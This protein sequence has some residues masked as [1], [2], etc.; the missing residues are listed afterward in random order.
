MMEAMPDNEEREYMRR[1]RQ[2]KKEMKDPYLH[3]EDDTN[4]E[5]MFEDLGVSEKEEVPE[6]DYFEKKE[7]PVR[8]GPT[9]RSHHEPES[10]SSYY[11][12]PSSDEESNPVDLAFSDDDGYVIP[13]NLASGSKRRL[14]KIRERVWYDETRENPHE[15]MGLRLCFI[16]VVQFRTSLRTFH[17]TQVRNFHYH[18]NN[19]KRIIV[20]CS[21]EGCPFYTKASM[22]AKEKTF[23]IRAHLH[24]TWREH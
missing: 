11:F 15:Q 12:R 7:K 8:C 20:M 10:Y 18:R 21:E 1:M 24:C 2:Q 19:N 6:A 13:F 23:C 4:V 16:H 22:V 14:K 17:I 5:E 9:S 3:Y